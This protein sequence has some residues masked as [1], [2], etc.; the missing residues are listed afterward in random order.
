M[1]NK[2]L[3]II[4]FLGIL[5]NLSAGNEQVFSDVRSKGMG[6]TGIAFTSLNNPSG[7]SFS[8][9]GFAHINYGNRFLVKELAES[10]IELAYPNKVMDAG[11]T[12]SHFGYEHY[13]E[14]LL[15]L[16]FSRR[17][18]SAFS[19]GIH[20]NYF[21]IHISE[22]DEQPAALT[23][24]VGIQWRPSSDLTF[25]VL[26]SNLL[27]TESDQWYHLSRKINVGF[28]YF[29]LSSFQLSGEYEKPFNAVPYYK[30]GMAY[31]PIKDLSFR[32]GM[33]GKPFIPTFGIGYCLKNVQLDLATINHSMLGLS[34]AIGITYFFR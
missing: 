3:I 23:A 4:L 5:L 29:I 28:A 22:V 26:F 2:L 1:K 20:A 12:F 18:A 19:L 24:D 34:P 13:N 32:I 25:G 15:R 16:T 7:I 27:I 31:Q 9:N 14:N 6:Y 8:E 10:T 21:F 33:Y 11:I 17:L 30:V